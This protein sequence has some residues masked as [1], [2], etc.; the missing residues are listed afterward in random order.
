MARDKQTKEGPRKKME[1][2]TPSAA[3]AGAG[4][5]APAAPAKPREWTLE[6]FLAALKHA[7]AFVKDNADVIRTFAR[8]NSA[9]MVKLMEPL[10][11]VMNAALAN[12][13]A[14]SKAS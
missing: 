5:P 11:E 10:S 2:R 14:S 13:A 4:K 6:D 1:R 8:K 12:E 3:T 9:A 7:G